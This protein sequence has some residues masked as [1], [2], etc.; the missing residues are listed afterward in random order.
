MSTAQTRSGRVES[1]QRARHIAFRGIPFARPP[2]GRLRFHAPVPPIPWAGVRA[3]REFGPSAIQNPAANP[4]L[5]VSGPTSEDCLYLNIYTPA[6]D[7]GRRPVMFWIHGGAFAFGSASQPQY[8]GGPL[9]HRGDVVVVT[10]NY[11]LGAFGYLCLPEP[12]RSRLDSTA[13]AGSLD[14]IAALLWVRE[15]IAGFGGDPDNVTIFGESAGAI[16]VCVLLGMPQA[17]GLFHKA[18]IQSARPKRDANPDPARRTR[19][20]LAEL[21]VPETSA[22]RL[23]ELP[24]DQI[25][26]AQRALSEKVDPAS[27]PIGVTGFAPVVDGATLPL[28]LD[29]IF[30]RGAGA[31]VP[32]VI[33]TTRDEINLFARSALTQLDQP[34]DEPKLIERLRSAIADPVD[35]RIAEMVDVYRQSRAAHDLPHGNRALSLAIWSDAI[36]RIPNIRFVESHRD[37]LPA[38]FM[39]LFTYESPALSGTL[40]ACHGLDVPFVF[41]T[42]D[43]TRRDAFVGSDASV[44]TLSDTMM[45]AWTT[46]AHRGDPSH[47]KLGDWV[48]YDLRWRATMVFDTKTRLQD[49]PLERERTAWEGIVPQPFAD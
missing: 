30:A 18:I 32:V 23:W 13:N 34:L 2:L 38:I 45:D 33:G 49:A 19:A 1:D 43:A 31:R 27:A 37:R 39:Y 9:A 41:G 8:D 42:L 16:S 14:Q 36:F 24:A 6:V 26:R 17:R 11:R 25:A 28:A 35:S 5:R 10:A 21:D 20:L 47:P 15:N 12:D 7:R 44:K 46:F 22:E 40:R 3:A 48:P 4:A 29:E